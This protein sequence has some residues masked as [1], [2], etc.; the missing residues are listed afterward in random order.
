MVQ[1]GPTCRNRIIAMYKKVVVHLIPRDAVVVPDALSV[2]RTVSMRKSVSM[3]Q[4]ISG[5]S[6]PYLHLDDSGEY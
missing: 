5:S 3:R 6:P 2:T 1:H 4:N